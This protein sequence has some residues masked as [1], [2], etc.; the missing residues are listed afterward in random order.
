MERAQ[1][2]SAVGNSLDNRTLRSSKM[3]LLNIIIDLEQWLKILANCWNGLIDSTERIHNN[4]VALG[5]VPRATRVWLHLL[6]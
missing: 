4:N 1:H 6:L 3:Q 5:S 2:L